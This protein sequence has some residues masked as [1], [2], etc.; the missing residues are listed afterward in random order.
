MKGRNERAIGI[1]IV[2]AGLVILLGKLGFFGFVGRNFWPLILL[3]P[4]IFLH[5]YYFFRKTSAVIM[6]P[7]GI[8]TVYGILFLICNIWGWHLMVYLWPVF[9]TGIA[10]GLFEYALFEYPRPASI[11]SSSIIL[12]AVS[13]VL[14]FITLLTTGFIYIIAALLIF[15]GIWLIFGRPKPNRRFR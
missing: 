12:L 3:I 1:F 10:L 5:L 15:A 2:I 14:L 11:Y 13:I 6:V 4:G 9:L 8:L 7:A